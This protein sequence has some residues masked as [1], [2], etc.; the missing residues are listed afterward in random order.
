MFDRIITINLN[1][2]SGE[3][4][5]YFT[6]SVWTTSYPSELGHERRKAKPAKPLLDFARIE[7]GRAQ[8]SYQPTDLCAL[9]EDLASN[10]QC[11]YSVT[12][13][14]VCPLSGNALAK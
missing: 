13:A 12:I 3:E 14:L 5:L 7:A 9:T 1:E 6:K 4:W 11:I 10:F 2:L 8:A